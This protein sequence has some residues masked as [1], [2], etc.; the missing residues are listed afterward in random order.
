MN[1]RLKILE[2]KEELKKCNRLVNKTIDI[3]NVKT[4]KEYEFECN[5]GH[6]F[7]T[8]LS[9]AFGNGSFCC[10]IC[11]NHRVLIGFNDMWTTHPEMARMLKNPEDGYKYTSGSNV[12]L[13]WKCYDC[14]NEFSLMPDKML[15][16]KTYCL[17]CGDS[18]S[19][20]EKFMYSFL[21]QWCDCFETRRYF[22]WS[23][24]KVYDFYLPEYNCIIETHGK[25][26]YEKCGFSH[27]GGRTL[28]EEQCNDEQK[29]YLAKKYGKVRNYFVI[30]CRKS[31]CDWIS[32][33]IIK[34]GL[35]ELLCVIPTTVDWD[36]CHAFAIGNLTREI[37]NCYEEGNGINELCEIFKMSYNTIKQRLKHGSALGWCS[38][39]PQK[40]IEESRKTIGVMVIEKMSKPIIQ[41]DMEGNEIGEFPSIQ[42]AQR[43]LSVSHI[44]DCII[45]KRKSAGGYRWRYKNENK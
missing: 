31:E 44:W 29:E 28:F 26:H 43:K 14:G 10:P 1:K 34:S 4:G 22:D 16:R 36:A 35:L 3:E 15:A 38:Y 6:K 2:I 27:L 25:Q 19:Y 21:E 24:G 12:C 20:P 41:M 45:G 42:E 40:A 7:T 9:N 8:L 18:I 32:I 39:N 13:D 17:M 37:C 11:S 30:D 33:N 5:C 23:D